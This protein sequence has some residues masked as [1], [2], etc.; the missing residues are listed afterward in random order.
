[1]TCTKAPGALKPC[2]AR[3]YDALVLDI[4]GTLLD[5]SEHLSERTRSAIAA[6]RAAGVVVMLATGRSHDGA[7]PWLKELALDTPA[8]VFNGAAVFDPGQDRL[9]ET[10]E[11]SIA[12][13]DDLLAYA[14]AHQLLPVLAR[15]E[16]QYVRQP[17]A[18][19]L[20]LL[21]GYR[22]LVTVANDA[23]PRDQALRVTLYSLQHKDSLTLLE[24]LQRP[25]AG[26]PV[27]CTHFP[28][29][30]LAHSRDSR[31]QVVDVQPA[32][33]GKALA[34]Q[35]LAR[36]YGIQK[37]RVVA[38]GDAP[39]DLPMLEIAGLG[40]A[41]GNARPEVKLAAKR[42][43]GHNDSD[44]LASLIEELFGAAD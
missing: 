9:I 30:E 29:S 8:V 34:L 17:Q 13:V 5:D 20:A 21:R 36:R 15:A 16:R 14:A 32:C 19:E 28:L 10:V 11:L 22:N 43:I 31:A 4:D 42:V 39:N 26:R 7:R 44:A 1:M 38:V 12:L 23:L 35:L 18:H 27:Y 3:D 41:M 6:A 37:E 2:M 24:D 33:D 25:I 40:V